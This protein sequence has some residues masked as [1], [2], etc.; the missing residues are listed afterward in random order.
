VSATQWKFT[1]TST[2]TVT[3]SKNAAAYVAPGSLSPAITSGTAFNRGDTDDEY[4]FKASAGGQD[5][6]WAGVVPAKEGTLTPASPFWNSGTSV[7]IKWNASGFPSGTTYNVS[8]KRFNSSNVFSG[9]AGESA[10]VAASPL[11]I[12]PGAASTDKFD[13]TV[14]AMFNGLARDTINFYRVLLT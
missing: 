9:T 12:N 1:W 2:G 14:T 10:G 6:V 7:D 3:V 5:M 4:T 8:W 11:N 13:V